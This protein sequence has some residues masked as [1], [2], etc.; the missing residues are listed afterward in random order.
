MKV[1]YN[2]YKLII[3]LLILWFV[4]SIVDIIADNSMPNAVHSQ[5]NMFVLMSR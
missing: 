1:L 3:M 5:L 4:F 2:L